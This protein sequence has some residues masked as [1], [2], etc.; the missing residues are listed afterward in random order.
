MTPNN[1]HW[2]VENGDLLNTQGGANLKS[3]RSF[4]DFQLH[5]EVNCPADGNS[6]IYLRGRYELQIEYQDVDANDP[7]HS[8]G[9]IYSFVAPTKMLPRTPGKWETFDVT[10]VGRRISIVR[11]GTK[12]VDNQEIPGPTGGALDSNEGAPGQFYIQGDHTGGLRY[13]NITIRVPKH[14]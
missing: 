13:R 9:A 12:T 8:I 3:T 11:N 1:N 5:F 7:F 10:L 2:T 4:E 6:G 14:S